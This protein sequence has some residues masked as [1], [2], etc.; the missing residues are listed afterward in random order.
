MRGERFSETAQHL[1]I[2]VVFQ[3]WD[4]IFAFRFICQ[5]LLESVSTAGEVPMPA[6]ILLR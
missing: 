3:L 1:H 6:M 2:A 4:F 5:S